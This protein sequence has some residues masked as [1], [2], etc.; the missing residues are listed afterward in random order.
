VS[1]VSAATSAAAAR[2]GSHHQS[3]G[4]FLLH[5]TANP[6][7]HRVLPAHCSIKSEPWTSVS[8][9][10]YGHHPHHPHAHHPGD[11]LAL[12]AHT[13]LS[14]GHHHPAIDAASYSAGHSYTNMPPGKKFSSD[15]SGSLDNVQPKNDP[16]RRLKRR[17]VVSR[18]LLVSAGT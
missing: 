15:Y 2:F 4:S 16:S 7:S 9:H 13:D 3:Y 11:P 18:F 14:T 10:R 1:G 8:H 12:T 5:Q 17:K 6:A